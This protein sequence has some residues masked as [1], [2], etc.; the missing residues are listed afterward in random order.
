MG[1]KFPVGNKKWETTKSFIS[2][3]FTQ[4]YHCHRI[5]GIPRLEH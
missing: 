3:P 2:E 1:T 4:R 5:A